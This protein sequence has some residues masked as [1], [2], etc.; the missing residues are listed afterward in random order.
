M[1]IRRVGLMK[2]SVHAKREHGRATILYGKGKIVY[3]E[4]KIYIVTF[5][6]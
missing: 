1:K 3:L 5:K 6:I 4:E 2:N